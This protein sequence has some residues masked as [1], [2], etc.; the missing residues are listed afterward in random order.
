MSITRLLP[1]RLPGIRAL[2]TLWYT[3]VFATLIL[4]FCFILYTTLKA[5]LASGID[6]ALHLR[7]QQIA[8][9]ISY[10]SGK[11]TIQDV[12]GELPG[13]DT[14]ATTGDPNATIQADVRS[15]V[16]V[17]ILVRIL[18]TKG[19]IIYI[20][21][22]F[23]ALVVPSTSISQP[24]HGTPWQG[25][26]IAHNGQAVRLYSAA[27]TDN[28][29]IFGVV[30]VGG[31]LEQL[32]TTLQSITIALLLI[33]PFVLLLSAFGSYW[34]AKGALRPIHR[35]TLSARNIKAGDLHRR[36]PVP[37]TKDEVQALALTLNEMIRR[38]DQ[39]FTQQRRFVADASHELR[40]PVTVIRNI[41]EIA[42]AQPLNLEEHLAVLQDLNAEAERLGQLIN[43]LLTL[44]RADEGQI[45]LDRELVR[46]DLLAYDVAASIESLAIER[47]IALQIEKMEPAT[48]E[49]DTARL[50]LA[51][52]GLVDNALTYT[53]AGGTV[54]LSVEV[55]GTSTCFS[56]HD[57]GIGIAPEDTAHIFERFYRAD[58]ARS[59]SAGGS[60][61][62][63]AIVDWVVRAHGGSITVESQVGKGSIFRMT[64]PMAASISV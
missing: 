23:H 6:T 1:I 27:L 9:G 13:L 40:T 20:S 37:Q 38:L 44:A 61:L 25:T 52:M 5:S 36:V 16:N 22:A 46:L 48:V 57:T 18:D 29:N 39:A 45:Q 7:T 41:T 11:I 19:Q 28:G 3:A 24:L 59:R 47:G 2:L 10:E 51:M 12:T 35:L 62:G 63:L 8:G 55:T 14:N 31:S 30:Q 64:L 4:L 54:T 34:L 21:P 50:I 58:P 43:D 33:T 49:G 56:V 53:N 42:L 17:G 26:V 32:T 15:D 60:G